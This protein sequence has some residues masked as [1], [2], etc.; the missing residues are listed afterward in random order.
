MNLK[1]DNSPGNDPEFVQS[2]YNVLDGMIE[3]AS[4]MGA[5]RK[6]WRPI[7]GRWASR[8]M[9]AKIK[10]LRQRF[11]PLYRERLQMI[12]QQD[13]H[14]DVKVPRDLIQMML[15]YAVEERTAEASSLDDI[16]RR[17]AVLNFG[18]MHQT[19]IT[20]HNLI[21]D[22]LD[23]DREFSTISVIDDEI[24]K[25]MDADDANSTKW[26]KAKLV[27][28][29][30]TD[31]VARETL[32]VHTF[33]GRAV[34]RIVIAK[35]GLVTE[36]GMRLPPGAKVSVLAYQVQTDAEKFQNPLKYEPFRFSR[37]REA[38][39]DPSSGKPGLNNLAFAA[40]SAEYLPFSHGRHA[41]P[42]RFM[43]DFEF[44]MTLAYLVRNYHLEFPESYGGKR[45]PNTWFAGFGIPPLSAKIRVK[46]K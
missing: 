25:V 36:D 7:L 20:L 30:K 37:S 8:T 16:T 27:A 6:I 22:V 21:L 34:D 15:Q 12:K 11:E 10:D 26:T 32:R 41:C 14:Q 13:Q 28:L 40:T 39:A 29:T 42:G 38:A 9:P 46:R 45:P 44:K 17:L 35:E 43:V 3:T 5:T 24:K 31:S 1:A 19:V 23:S 4:A 18:T 2:C 33:L